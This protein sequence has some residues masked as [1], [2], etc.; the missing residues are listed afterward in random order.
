MSGGKIYKCGD[1]MQPNKELTDKEYSTMCNAK[2]T[3]YTLNGDTLYTDCGHFGLPMVFGTDVSDMTSLKAACQEHLSS[4]SKKC[5]P[6]CCGDGT[7]WDT[8]SS[9]CVNK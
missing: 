6:S 1:L 5:T 2:N 3:S 7:K 8:D 4:S 9:K